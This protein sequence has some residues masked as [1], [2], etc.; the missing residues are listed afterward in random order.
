MN[1]WWRLSSCMG[2]RGLSPLSSIRNSRRGHTVPIR[3][4]AHSWERPCEENVATSGMLKK[5]GGLAGMIP[6]LPHRAHSEGARWTAAIGIIP[7]SPGTQWP[8]AAL[9]GHFE[10]PE[11]DYLEGN[12][13]S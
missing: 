12:Y 1:G 5:G 9:A 2:T 13:Q 11:E 7:T 3:S 8:A 10:H 4:S 6:V